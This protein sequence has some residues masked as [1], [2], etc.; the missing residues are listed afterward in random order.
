M[1]RKTLLR[2]L[3]FVGAVLVAAALVIPYYR[4][5]LF[6]PKYQGVPLC[7]WQERARRQIQGDD[8]PD[9]AAKIAKWVQPKEEALPADKLTREEKIAIW[10]TLLDDPAPA[11]R[12]QAI[13]RLWG[14]HARHGHF[15]LDYIG[16]VNLSTGSGSFKTL[17]A[18]TAMIWL[19]GDVIITDSSLWSSRS[20]AHGSIQPPPPV[21]PHLTR[22][23]D[24]AS[25]QVRQTAFNAL[26][27]Q[28]EEAAPA[29][30]RLFELLH[31]PEPV[32]RRQ[33]M[34][35]LNQAHPRTRDWLEPLLAML[36]DPTAEVRGAAADCLSSWSDRRS[37]TAAGPPLVKV[38][39]DP[40]PVVRIQAAACLGSLQLG[41]REAAET[42][43]G[44]LRHPDAQVRRRALATIAPRMGPAL[45]DDLAR[46]AQSD[47]NHDVRTT[48]IGLLPY[49]GKQA[50]PLLVSL[51]RD[52]RGEVR[53]A[54]V[55]ALGSLGPQARAAT[56]FLLADLESF[57]ATGVQALASIRDP[58]AV[59]RLIELLDHHDLRG[60][61]LSALQ[62]LQADARPAVPKLVEM[63]EHPADQSQQ[64]FQALLAIAGQD[65]EVWSALEKRALA[66]IASGQ[67][68]LL[69]SFCSQGA[70]ARAVVPALIERLEK[71]EPD[72]R[73][74]F[75]QG[76]GAIGGEARAAVPA[77]LRLAKKD[78]DELRSAVISALGNITADEQQVV[79][80]L[81]EQLD[82]NWHATG[83][84]QALAQFGRRAEA[85][86]PQ[87]LA[88]LESW[89]PG[90]R[91]TA[92]W[93]L[94]AV[95]PPDDAV[96]VLAPS[97]RDSDPD[98]RTAA[99]QAM[100]STRQRADFLGRLV[101]CLH[102]PN[103]HVRQTTARVLGDLGPLAFAAT[104]SL[105]DVLD[106]DSI[107][108]SNT[109][110]YALAQIEP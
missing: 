45:Y 52:S 38:L 63:L 5:L 81:M 25:E 83:V 88:L 80:W 23:L 28:G 68:N 92:L 56:P 37:A 104:S 95:L 106:D 65:H 96:R 85:A 35:T 69:W 93:A 75:V 55:N 16:F 11:V 2:G 31:H 9:W 12:V 13:Q 61:A 82:R 98:V 54:A 19:S 44:S 3:A 70:R 97:L 78:D 18:D 94:A 100:E 72:K 21:A 84:A 41:L 48:A 32:R 20:F 103:D 74:S 108:V 39:R 36:D 49:G 51:L 27:G 71:C 17:S 90:E 14:Q 99:I 6:G 101:P 76:L 29:F 50:V 59:P 4:Q 102:D 30:P 77:L 24:D 60:N 110:L 42:L 87:L 53:T 79:P 67:H 91:T 109:A 64:L 105:G 40:D 22:M 58:D 86:R 73:L 43:R 8:K 47:P 107:L 62:A 7:A 66:E 46:C 15:E 1:R 26:G 10:E 57:A 34:E 89:E 33:A